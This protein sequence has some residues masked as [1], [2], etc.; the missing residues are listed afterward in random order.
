MIN[1]KIKKYVDLYIDEIF[2][3]RHDIINWL[4]NHERKEL[5]IS[6]L[7]KEI[8]QISLL[9]PHLINENE[10]KSLSKEFTIMFAKA[11]ISTKEQSLINTNSRENK[12]IDDTLKG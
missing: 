12:M 1:H 9:R 11:A 4:K 5:L 8:N 10:I 6:N 2:K 7:T 3:G